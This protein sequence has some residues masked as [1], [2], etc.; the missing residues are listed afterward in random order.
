MQVQ[1]QY[2]KLAQAYQAEYGKAGPLP[3]EAWEFFHGL[4]MLQRAEASGS[5]TEVANALW[6]LCLFRSVAKKP[7]QKKGF[8]VLLAIVKALPPPEREVWFAACQKDENFDT[9]LFG[10]A[11]RAAMVRAKEK[12]VETPSG[13]GLIVMTYL[14]KFDE[15]QPWQR[16]F[17]HSQVAAGSTLAFKKGQ[18]VVDVM[19]PDLFTFMLAR[20]LLRNSQEGLAMQLIKGSPKQIFS[21]TIDVPKPGGGSDKHSYYELYCQAPRN[22]QGEGAINVLK[23]FVDIEAYSDE[24]F[25]VFC[26]QMEMPD[27]TNFALQFVSLARQ[28]YFVTGRATAAADAPEETPPKRCCLF[29]GSSSKPPPVASPKV[30][31][32]PSK[33]LTAPIPLLL[34]RDLVKR[35]K[36]RYRDKDLHRALEIILLLDEN[37]IVAQVAGDLQPLSLVP[38]HANLDEAG[39]EFLREALSAWIESY[40]LLILDVNRPPAYKADARRIQSLVYKEE[41]YTWQPTQHSEMD[42]H[43]RDVKRDRRH[44]FQF[45]HR[46]SEEIALVLWRFFDVS[47]SIHPSL[48]FQLLVSCLNMAALLQRPSLNVLD[49][50]LPAGGPLHAVVSMSVFAYMPRIAHADVQRLMIEPEFYTESL[51]GLL[52]EGAMDKMQAIFT[53]TEAFSTLILAVQKLS[54]LEITGSSDIIHGDLDRST[55]EMTLAHIT[56]VIEGN[57]VCIDLV[58]KMFVSIL[59]THKEDAAYQPQDSSDMPSAFTLLHLL[60]CARR[61]RAACDSIKHEDVKK[62]FIE[63]IQAFLKLPPRQWVPLFTSV[64]TVVF[65]LRF[66]GREDLNMAYEKFHKENQET[67]AKD[68]NMK[69][70]LVE[71]QAVYGV[72]LVDMKQNITQLNTLDIKT[73]LGERKS[74]GSPSAPA[75]NG[76]FTNRDWD[77]VVDI[78][79]AAAMSMKEKYSLPMLPHHTQLITLL[80]FAVQVCIGPSSSG[81]AKTILAR[82]GTGEGKSWIIGMLAAF[83][84]KRGMTAHVA[85]DNQTLLE[86]DFRTMSDLFRKLN[87]KAHKGSFKPEYQVVYCSAMDIEMY[88]M[89]QM[90]KG[91]TEIDFRNCAMIVDEVDSLIVDENA[92]QSYVFDD[93]GASDVCEWWYKEGRNG[94]EK[95]MATLEPWIQNVCSKIKAADGEASSKFEGRDYHEDEKSG[96]LWALDEKTAAVK[97]NAWFLWLEALRKQRNPEHKI[98]YK[99]RQMIVCQKACFASYSFIFGLTGSLGTEA[100]LEYTKKQFNAKCFHVP[101]FLDTCQDMVKPYPKCVS[102]YVGRDSDQQMA[103]TSET[104]KNYVTKVPI[105]VVVTNPDRVKKIISDLKKVLP[106]HGQGD[107]LGPGIIELLDMPGKEAEFQQ[108]VETATLPIEIEGK[109]QWRVTITTA[110]GARGQDYQISDDVVDKNGGLLLILEYIPDSE[111][112]WIQFLGRTARH[113][114]PGQYAVILNREDYKDA[115]GSESGEGV[116]VEKKVLGLINKITAEKLGEAENQ[117]ERGTLMHELTGIF[118]KWVKSTKEADKTKMDKFFKWVDL[119]ED[120]SGRTVDD[121]RKTYNELKAGRV[122]RIGSI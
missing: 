119:C 88:F 116:D 103:K 28:K 89:D 93:A 2:P 109:K 83:V 101:P 31:A 81:A 27:V 23:Y 24:S 53:G 65:L 7:E 57:P 99:C 110:A 35:Y 56:S 43:G 5:E 96:Q 74:K 13:V 14:S 63:I 39:L 58:G 50:F 104:V 92:Y 64:E 72:P 10:H 78:A 70:L 114:H 97:R 25:E 44:Y 120:F 91:V 20:Q 18:E 76:K 17:M 4:N 16:N 49:K 111:R 105:V 95:Q 11:D 46:S 100:E 87:I 68:S 51:Q 32:G 52:K 29:G 75:G 38:I 102:T 121:I 22:E 82:V 62:A 66:I 61:L 122:P 79:T 21:G 115:L 33:L 117:L 80:M 94:N 71:A 42:D 6:G 47:M 113:D 85:I 55:W 90:R 67:F 26:F 84:A 3:P 45:D 8:D 86:R 69:D 15:L 106:G 37:Q 12:A 60:S 118:W 98:Q 107:K 34:F 112:E 40:W 1:G 108:L 73:K 77:I 30:A 36:G 54:R 48:V 59:K 41:V 9:L 19:N